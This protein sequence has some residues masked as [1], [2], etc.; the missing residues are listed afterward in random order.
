LNPPRVQ[1]P[2]PE[3]IHNAFIRGEEAVTELF[4]SVIDTVRMLLSHTDQLREQLA[5]N[6][7]DSSKP[8]SGDGLKKKP[9][10]GSL[11]KPG[12]KPDGGQPGHKGHYPEMA[13]T[14]DRIVVHT[15]RTCGNCHASLKKATVIGH[16]RRQVSD[17]PPI[18]PEIT[19][20]RIDILRCPK[21]GHHNKAEFPKEVSQPTQYG[22]GVKS[23]AVYFNVYHH[24]PLKRT[25]LISEH[26]SDHRISEAAIAEACGICASEVAPANEHI[27][28]QLIMSDAVNSDETGIGVNKKLHWL[29][30]ASSPE[31]TC[32]HIHPKRGGQGLSDAG[33]LP[34]FHGI[35]VRDHRKAY[36]G[37][38]CGHG[39]CNAHHLRELKFV[40][41]QYDQGWAKNLSDLLTEIYPEVR[42]V[43]P[44]QSRLPP[45]TIGE[46][47]SRYDLI[48]NQGLSVNPPSE[49][50][51]GRRGRT[52]QSV[53]RN[54]PERLRIHKP[55]TLRFMYDFRVPSDNN[56]AERDIRMMKVKQKVSGTFRTGKGADIFCRIRSYISAAQKNACNIIHAI[57][58]AFQG[59][60]FM[61]I[62][63][64]E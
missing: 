33:I 25:A 11:R 55:E 19:G 14:P 53:P 32:Y 41:E 27:R 50:K 29:T 54:L 61:P 12:E 58:R 26:I 8:P 57:Q 18:R 13:D 44:Y 56:L 34:E 64:A 2:T 28:K 21:C 31:F 63:T 16:D 6:S 37:F 36:F 46:S 60:P 9:R 38:P 24:I 42:K 39:L 48:I 4:I 35:G 17:I 49:K 47:G 59:N 62:T 1:L 51:E 20:H 45:E 23:H 52:E 10:T 5:K 43:R 7:A 15:V 3:D 30:V 22:A 40:R